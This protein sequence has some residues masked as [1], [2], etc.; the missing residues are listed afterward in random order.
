MILD[1]NKVFKN[2]GNGFSSNFSFQGLIDEKIHQN[3]KEFLITC[4]EVHLLQL[5]VRHE[6]SE[7][8]TS[9]SYLYIHPTLINVLV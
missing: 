2:E 4:P 9:T 7:T 6:K 5:K 8:S 1:I 3:T